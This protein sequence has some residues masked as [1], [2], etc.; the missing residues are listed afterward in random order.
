MTGEQIIVC[1]V[2]AMVSLTIYLIGFAHGW[3]L[4]KRSGEA[5]GV[6]WAIGSP[7]RGE[8]AMSI[9]SLM[10]AFLAPM[11]RAKPDEDDERLHELEIENKALRDR[12]NDLTRINQAL[13]RCENGQIAGLQAELRTA[14]QRI[15]DYR[16]RLRSMGVPQGQARQ[17]NVNMP[18]EEAQNALPYPRPSA[19]L[20]DL[21]QAQMQTTEE[22]VRAFC[23]CTPSRS[24][25]LARQRWGE[26]LLAQYNAVQWRQPDPIPTERQTVVETDLVPLPR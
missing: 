24:E 9:S 12:L 21:M 2:S 23:T 4:G 1:V 17:G 16:V 14:A 11:V 22:A 5:D 10:L 26:E 6:A 7:E 3:R 20:L 19:A 8:E 25:M 15:E 13:V 18:L